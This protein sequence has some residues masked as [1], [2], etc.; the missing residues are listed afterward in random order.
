[1]GRASAGGQKGVSVQQAG[2]GKCRGGGRGPLI[3]SMS[4]CDKV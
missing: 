4:L 2:A 3:M 1:M